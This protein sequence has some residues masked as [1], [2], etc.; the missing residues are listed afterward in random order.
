MPAPTAPPP[1]A[2]VMQLIFGKWI[3]MAMSV[4]A[5]LR[6][7]DKLTAGPR[8]ITEL[9]A[10]TNT[11]APSLY[12]V[13]RA[14]ASAGVFAEDADGRFCQTP[15]SELLR[16]EVPGSM[17]AVA[18]YC[19]S[20]WSWRPWGQLL[21]SVR[22][23][24]TAFDVVF[25]EPA[26]DY[27]AKHPRESAVF[28]DGMTGFSSRMAPAVAEAYDFGRFDT[29]VDVGGGH[30][31]LLCTLLKHYAGPRGIVYDSPHVAEG[32]STRIAEFG[33]SDR[34]RAEGGD[35]F[36]S[37]PKGGDAYLMKH[38]IHDWPDDRATTILRNCRAAAK[39]RA[40]VIL[41]EMVIPPGNE[42][43]PG[44]LL[45]LEMLV[46]ASGKERTEREY[47]ELLAGAGW[48]LTRI[49]STKSPVVVIEG[50]AA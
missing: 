47:T 19:G 20:D 12:R 10:E 33:L 48:T 7:A 29:I 18:D 3:A 34:C 26:F 49:V 36:A 21:E 43:S 44:K 4:A 45:D 14:L 41:V 17:R 11:H 25:G 42:P 50:A 1:E 31:H 2:V 22:T 35:F 6:V 24:R 5:K 13:L 40:K 37:V 32:A 23:G 28:N 16:T 39:D 27:L 8:S 38:I 15:A 46:I 9:A 30:G